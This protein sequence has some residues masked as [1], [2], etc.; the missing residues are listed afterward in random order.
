[1]QQT[2]LEEE[3][4]DL[5]T[6]TA[7]TCADCGEPFQS[8]RRAPRC[9]L[10]SSLRTGQV[11]PATVQCPGCGV[12]HKIAILA[13]HKFCVTCG[14]PATAY[15][16][17]QAVADELSA[18]LDADVAHADEQTRARFEAACA[19]LYTGRLGDRQLTTE[20]VR[21]AWQK[22]IDKGDDLSPLLVLYDRAA[23]AAL[24]QQRAGE[25]R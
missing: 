17:L 24:A 10:C 14:D 18:R 13:P 7:Q 22:A 2:F 15:A 12:E 9:A 5:F 16:K 3:I 11:G 25:G 6:L 21:A 8:S 23:A 19:M 1:M 4:D 20:Q